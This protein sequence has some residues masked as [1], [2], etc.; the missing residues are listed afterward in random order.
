MRI[1]LKNFRSVGEADITLRPLT[2][3]YGE[4]SAGK[5]NLVRALRAVR[6]SLTGCALW[7]PDNTRIDG[8]SNTRCKEAWVRIDIRVP[9]RDSIMLTDDHLTDLKLP[10]LPELVDDLDF[11][12]RLLQISVGMF[13]PEPK[14]GGDLAEVE[15][16]EY[17]HYSID[18]NGLLC[19]TSSEAELPDVRILMNPEHPLVKEGHRSLVTSCEWLCSRAAEVAQDID[20]PSANGPARVGD[21]LRQ[22]YGWT[23]AALLVSTESI[24]TLSLTYE[25]RNSSVQRQLRMLT[26]ESCEELESDGVLLPPL[27]NITFHHF[28][29]PPPEKAEAS[30]CAIELQGLVRYLHSAVLVN[31]EGLLGGDRGVS[32]AR[33]VVERDFPDDEESSAQLGKLAQLRQLES[34]LGLDFRFHI[35]NRDVKVLDPVSRNPFGLYEVGLGAAYVLPILCFMVGGRLRA[36]EQ[37]EVHLHPKMQSRLGD[38]VVFYANKYKDI[39]DPE[40]IVETHS[41]HLLMRVLRRIREHS[42]HADRESIESI[43]DKKGLLISEDDVL[44]LYAI[45]NELGATEYLELRVNSDGE[46]IDRWP[47]GFFDSMDE[48]LFLARLS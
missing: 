25:R 40:L 14:E 39:P 16:V 37:P 1:Q 36:V 43:A 23:T 24:D 2:L 44:V 31:L 21:F 19:L 22:R 30:A 9:S 27:Y 48:D 32:Y 35:G 6:K 47:P 20:P 10:G 11:G 17:V 15:H 34:V 45:R 12:G 8:S 42:N 13:V 38:L 46:F 33:K 3:L 18:G 7:S 26:G 4:N 5:T 29:M 28:E 41:E